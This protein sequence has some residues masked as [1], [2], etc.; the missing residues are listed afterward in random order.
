VFGAIAG[1]AEF[2]LATIQ[3]RMSRRPIH[4]SKISH[5]TK[6][7]ISCRFMND[8]NA[9]RTYLETF[10]HKYPET[11]ARDKHVALKLKVPISPFPEIADLVAKLLCFSSDELN[12]IEVGHRDRLFIAL[13]ALEKS[14]ERFVEFEECD[15]D[16]L[17]AIVSQISKEY[18]N[19]LPVAMQAL[20][21]LRADRLEKVFQAAHNDRDAAAGAR[22]EVEDIADFVRQTGAATAVAY[23]EKNFEETRAEHA[24]YAS[25]WLCAAGVCGVA[26]M[27]LVIC[28]LALHAFDVGDI[29]HFS[30]GAVLKFI[31]RGVLVF[32]LLALVTVCLRSHRLHRSLAVINQHRRNALRTFE[33]FVRAAGDEKTKDTVLLAATHVIFAATPS[34]Y[35]GGD[36][37]DPMLGRLID[38]FKFGK[39]GK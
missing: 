4:L 25:I 36:D 15:Q 29:D 19:T 10:A 2:T 23:R 21:L 32:L 30:P 18:S 38:I 9:L 14:L 17:Y 3:W 11:L 39:G 31:V 24:R 13:N 20:L 6:A 33:S 22:K 5:S 28:F 35:L 8:E 7:P 37:A 16:K 12:R 27:V 34:R 1:E 26:T